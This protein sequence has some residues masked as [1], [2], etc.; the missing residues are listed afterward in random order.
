[1][2]GRMILLWNKITRKNVTPSFHLWQS[3]SSVVAQVQKEI[4]SFA[5]FL[6][7]SRPQQI[8]ESS[9]SKLTSLVIISKLLTEFFC[10]N[11]FH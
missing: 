1:M 6:L 2:I 4:S 10:Q 9:S 8:Y 11:I 5:V 3:G 7:I